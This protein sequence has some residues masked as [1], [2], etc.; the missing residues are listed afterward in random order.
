[1]TPKSAQA[2]ARASD[3]LT[4]SRVTLRL[5]RPETTIHGSYYAMFWVARAFVEERTGA[6][7]KTHDGLISVFSRLA[8]DQAPTDHEIAGL[9]GAS[10]ARRLAADYDDLP[11][12]DHN[13]AEAALADAEAFVAL[14]RRLLTP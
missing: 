3:A 9:L 8:Q 13:D 7:P 12:F 14:C 2:L 4:T 11:Q 5:N 6:R 1:M 10:L